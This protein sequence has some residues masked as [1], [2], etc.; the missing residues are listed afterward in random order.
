MST[1]ANFVGRERELATGRAALDDALAGDGRLLL[2]AGEA[3]I[4]KSRFADELAAEA[5]VRGARVLWGRCWEA[6]GAPAYW[7]WVQSIRAYLRERD[8]DA[9]RSELSSGAGDLVQMLPE[10]A[11]LYEDLEPS[12]SG[13]PQS[14]RFR[15]FESTARFL[16]AAAAERPLVVVL[17]DLH[18][19]DAS[20]LLLLRFVAGELGGCRILLVGAYR[21]PELGS[22]DP[23]VAAL[24][25][26]LRLGPTRL[27]RLSGVGPEAVARYIEDVA[28][29]EPSRT[30]SDAIDLGGFACPVTWAKNRIGVSRAITADSA[31]TYWPS[32]AAGSGGAHSP[33]SSTPPSAPGLARCQ[34]STKS[35][36]FP[37]GSGQP[38]SPSAT[39]EATNDDRRDIAGMV[40]ADARAP[41][42]NCCAARRGERNSDS[43][44]GKDVLCGG[45][46][47]KGSAS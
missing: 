12:H 34:R 47:V 43:V 30:L 41:S 27:L 39:S 13:D 1:G 6:G 11:E 21:D 44:S 25:E 33:A 29:A 23:R 36:N 17:D 10:L 19:A 35:S 32:S 5:R 14:A 46:V 2:L 18:A 8:P 42:A 7:P 26:L 16:R 15:L 20:S 40:S 28:G 9:L 31:K 45:Q 24:S 3:G 22:G 38:A 4:G 37:A